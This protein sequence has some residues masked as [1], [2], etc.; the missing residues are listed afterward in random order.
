MDDEMIEIAVL[1]R[2][3]QLRKQTS[4]EAELA[5]WEM[6]LPQWGMLNAVAAQP[7][8]STHALALLTGQSDQSAG[9]AVARLEHRGLVER[10]SGHG[11]AILHRTT[12]EGMQMLGLCDRAVAQTMRTALSGFNGDEVRELRD[13][14]ERL[15]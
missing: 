1:L 5:Q 2:R 12:A 10:R 3:A 8:S 13:L 15:A 6:T 14:L 4:C 7:D 11:K 9:A